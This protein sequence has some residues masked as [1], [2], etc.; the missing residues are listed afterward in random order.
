MGRSLRR[1]FRCWRSCSSVIEVV[2]TFFA[3]GRPCTLADVWMA[4]GAIRAVPSTHAVWRSGARSKR[5]AINRLMPKITNRGRGQGRLRSKR[6]PQVGWPPA[7][8]HTRGMERPRSEAT[9]LAEGCVSMTCA[10]CDGP[11]L[12]PGTRPLCREGHPRHGVPCRIGLRLVC[13][14]PHGRISQH[15]NKICRQRP[16][17]HD[18]VAGS[19]YSGTCRILATSSGYIA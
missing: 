1:A 5:E 11:P 18:C 17:I 12:W 14:G 10:C 3:Q 16:S 13:Q 2:G 9:G 4:H 6:P 15:T 7:A 8:N 19:A